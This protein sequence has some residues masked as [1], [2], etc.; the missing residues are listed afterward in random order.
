LENKQSIEI[1]NENNTLELENKVNIE[2]T[3][4]KIIIENEKNENIK[5]FENKKKP[6]FIKSTNGIYNPYMSI[7]FHLLFPGTGKINLINK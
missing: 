3:N 4:D 6:K 1:E 5:N 2:E 7:F